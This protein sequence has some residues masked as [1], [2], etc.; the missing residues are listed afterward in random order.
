MN[1]F[2]SG[3]A[4]VFIV[5]GILFAAFAS[6][7]LA[8]TNTQGGGDYLNQQEVERI[9]DAQEIEMR[10][11]VFLYIANRRLKVLTGELKQQSK[12]EEESWGPLPSG[13]PEDLLDGYRR[14]ISEL[15]DK[16]DD[17][18]EHNP[19]ADGLKKALKHVVEET[20]K[21]I[22]SLETWQANAKTEESKRALQNAMDAAKTANTGAKDGLKS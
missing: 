4:S 8:M 6:N 13:N 20:D 11:Q 15:M 7:N 17:S 9:Q 2:P 21:Q 12:K 16:I 10:T 1:R 22:K 19:K 3:V 5:L 14:A 18:Y